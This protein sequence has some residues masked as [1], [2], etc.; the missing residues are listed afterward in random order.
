MVYDK[1]HHEGDSKA[2]QHECVEAGGMILR[3]QYD[4]LWYVAKSTMKA[5][6]KQNN[7][8]VSVTTDW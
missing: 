4:G 6:V 1:E 7:M 8:I 2:D 5:T 3:I